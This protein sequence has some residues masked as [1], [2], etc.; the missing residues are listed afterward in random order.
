[1]RRRCRRVGGGAVC[2]GGGEDGVSLLVRRQPGWLPSATPGCPRPPPPPLPP[3][4]SLATHAA[5]SER[6]AT[7]C[8]TVAGDGEEEEDDDDDDDGE[9]G[10][11]ELLGYDEYGMPVLASEYDSE[12]DSDY[13]S[14]GELWGCGNARALG[15]G[16]SARPPSLRVVTGLGRVSC[17]GGSNCKIVGDATALTPALPSLAMYPR[18]AAEDE[19]DL[20]LD[21]DEDGDLDVARRHRGSVSIVDV[22]VRSPMAVR[23]RAGRQAGRRV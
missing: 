15:V 21:E 17:A 1:M 22:T 10:P 19:S 4:P 8:C 12:E 5:A 11:G 3:P 13:E 14:E 6:H 20:E 18:L 16:C 2:T 9:F 7:H 23:G